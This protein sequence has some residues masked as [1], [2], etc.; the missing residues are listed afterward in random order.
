MRTADGLIIRDSELP[1]QIELR[2][3][4][5]EREFYLLLPA[6]K[7]FGACLNKV[8]APIRRIFKK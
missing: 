3:Q 6:R 2:G 8:T 1:M 7:K 4:N 5:G